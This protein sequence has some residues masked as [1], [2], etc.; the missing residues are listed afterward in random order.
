VNDES[1]SRFP[2]IDRPAESPSGLNRAEASVPAPLV[3]DL[4]RDEVVLSSRTWVVKV[5]TSVLTGPDGTLDPARI[6]HLAEQISTVMDR[7]RKVAL[8]SSGAVGAGMGQLGWKRRPDNLPQLQAAAAVGQA[9][10]IRAYDQGLRRHRRHAAQLLLTHEDFDSRPRYLNMRNTLHALFEYDAVPIINEND[11]I[12]IDE[13]KFGDNDRL[14]AMVTNLLQASLLVILSVVDGLYRTDPTVATDAEVVGLVPQ[15]DEQVLLL[16]GAGRSSM[17]T[18]G[19]QSKLAAARLVT[20]AGGS[21]I[22]ASGTQPE[23]LTRILAGERIGTLFLAHGASHRARKRW[24]GLTARPRGH[25]TVDAGARAALE[26]GSKS[27]LAIGI[28]EVVGEFEK[29]DV[30]GIR[31]LTGQEFARGLTNYA[32]RDALRIRGQHTHKAR[33]TLGSTLYDEVVHRDN[34]VLIV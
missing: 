21:V 33:Q 24:I 25:Y 23:P 26:S 29:G 2:T 17:G 15:I 14:A 1:D 6:D 10:L 3:R 12:S 5:G 8:V 11:T 16:A 20:Q 28:L 27:L 30:V 31:D 18:G 22:I 34:L 32:T 13:I 19:M 4:V 9:Y 7:G